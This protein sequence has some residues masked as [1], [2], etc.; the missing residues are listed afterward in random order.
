MQPFMS[1][2]TINVKLIRYLDDQLEAVPLGQVAQALSIDRNTVK[3]HIAELQTLI[4]QHFST[5]DMT[6]TFSA[7]AGVQFQ[8][9]ATVNLNQIMLLLTDESL[10]TKLVKSTFDGVLHSLGQFNDLNFV[11]DSTAKRHVKDLQSHLALF[12]LHYS[13]AS[14]ELVGDEAMVRLCYYRWRG[15]LASKPLYNHAGNVEG[16]VKKLCF[17]TARFRG[18]IRRLCWVDD[19]SRYFWCRPRDGTGKGC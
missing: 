3:T 16:C 15:S 12:G 6:L 4:Q 10:M 5:T 14:H 9:R 19:D 8:R 2:D 1:R 11:S 13:P 7:Q 17:S 18:R